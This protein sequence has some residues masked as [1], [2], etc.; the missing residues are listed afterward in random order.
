MN[1]L[2]VLCPVRGAYSA[3]FKRSARWTR[4]APAGFPYPFV[5]LDVR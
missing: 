1:T 4:G 3:A 2:R 5:F